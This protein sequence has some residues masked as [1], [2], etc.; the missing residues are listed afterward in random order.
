MELS[1]EEFDRLMKSQELKDWDN[2]LNRLI[3]HI[4]DL[5]TR[6]VPDEEKEAIAEDIITDMLR[7]SINLC[8]GIKKHEKD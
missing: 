5:I 2:A 1:E 3:D 4:T 8:D 7:C 6:Q